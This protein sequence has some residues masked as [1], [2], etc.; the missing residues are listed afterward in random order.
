MARKLKDAG[1]PSTGLPLDYPAF[2]ESLRSRVRQAQTKA[3]LSVNREL[4]RLYW[5]IGREIVE[6]QEQAGWGQSVL[7]RLAD[8][9][10]KAL[11]GVGGFSR[12]NVFRMRAFYV[13]YRSPPKVAQPVRQ[14][15]AS[16]KVAQVVTQLGEDGPPGAVGLIPWGHNVV[17]LQK[18]KGPVERLW[19]ASKTLEHGWSRAVLTVQIESGLFARQGNAVTNFEGRLPA[20]QSDL[21]QQSFKDPYLFD[22]LTLRQKAVERD[23][24]GGLVAHIEKFLLELGAG[25]AFV[26]RQVH[27]K[28]GESDFYLDLLFYHFRL[29]CF[30]VIDLK[31]RAFTPEDAGKMNFYLSAVDSLMRHTTDQPTIGLILCKTSDRVVAEYALRDIDKPI[32]VAEWQTKL[33]QSLPESFKGSLPSIEEIEAEFGT[34]ESP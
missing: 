15:K 4:I 34:E 29:R 17:M 5:D 11:P 30:V 14:P 13:A 32:G 3:M 1:L 25:F 19:Y 8:D 18:V 26:G 28:V 10:Q 7:E 23:L 16:K 21:A 24:E 27:L 2:L 20:P 22:F 33:V 6:R 31:M 12:S 9:L